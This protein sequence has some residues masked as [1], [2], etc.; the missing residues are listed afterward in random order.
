MSGLEKLSVNQLKELIRDYKKDNCPPYSKLKKADLEA[1]VSKLGLNIT[2]I[3]KKPK[4]PK[5][6][7]PKPA[8]QPAPK[9]EKKKTIGWTG[10]GE[11]PNGMK[12]DNFSIFK[13]AWEKEGYKV[14]IYEPLSKTKAYKEELKKML[15]GLDTEIVAMYVERIENE[16]TVK[17]LKKI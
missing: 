17:E 15:E 8:P 1:L 7:E 12:T 5:K 3:P 10:M 6:P 2:L 16:D 4:Q 14:I 9:P 11:L 13:N